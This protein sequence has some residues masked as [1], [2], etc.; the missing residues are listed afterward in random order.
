MERSRKPR[1]PKSNSRKSSV[2]KK[3]KT[4]AD[5]AFGKRLLTH[6]QQIKK[7]NAQKN[8]KPRIPKKA[9]FVGK[10]F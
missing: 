7:E 1:V 5:L 3:S 9:P 2:N 10:N 8:Q 4:G 6:K